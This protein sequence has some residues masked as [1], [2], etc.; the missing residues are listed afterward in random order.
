MGFSRPFHPIVWALKKLGA[1]C[2]ACIDVK[3]TREQNARHAEEQAKRDK[4]AADAASGKPATNVVVVAPAP[5]G[6]AAA[7]GSSGEPVKAPAAAA[8]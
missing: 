5:A 3:E 2:W 4:A 7:P 6:E 1:C 8:V